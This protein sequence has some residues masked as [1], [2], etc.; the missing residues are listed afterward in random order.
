MNSIND[1]TRDQ[2][3]LRYSISVDWE[4]FRDNTENATPEAF[5][6]AFENDEE[7]KEGYADRLARTGEDF[8]EVFHEVYNRLYA[9]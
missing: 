8:K 6:E 4:I 5:L 1:L 3:T 7:W 2:R 9:N